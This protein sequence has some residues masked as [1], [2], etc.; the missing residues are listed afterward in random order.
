MKV[1]VEY[2]R[3]LPL[4]IF[5]VLLVV[6]PAAVSVAGLGIAQCE[7]DFVVGLA[8]VD[9]LYQHSWFPFLDP[10]QSSFRT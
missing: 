5:A 7:P 3:W 10:L 2:P 6:A 1:A 8:S 9:P 4:P